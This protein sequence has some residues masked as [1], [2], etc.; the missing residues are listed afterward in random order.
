MLSPNFTLNFSFGCTN[1]F[2]FCPS[3]FFVISEWWSKHRHIFDNDDANQTECRS[4][5]QQQQQKFQL[6]HVTTPSAQLSSARHIFFITINFSFFLRSTHSITH[7]YILGFHL[8]VHNV[9]RAKKSFRWSQSSSFLSRECHTDMCVARRDWTRDGSD[10]LSRAAVTA[11]KLPLFSPL[12][13]SRFGGTEHNFVGWFLFSSFFFAYFS[14]NFKPVFFFLVRE[15]FKLSLFRLW[16]KYLKC[17]YV[18][19]FSNSTHHAHTHTYTFAASKVAHKNSSSPAFFPRCQT[20]PDLSWLVPAFTSSLAPSP[21]ARLV[22]SSAQRT[23]H[24]LH[25]YW[26]PFPI[27]AIF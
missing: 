17:K 14:L 2:F 5:K 13:L 1:V 23:R 3:V 12:N 6:Y 20:C 21:S 25:S 10:T 9:L 4:L 24:V 11:N 15:M 26:G 18:H 27:C 19:N 16:R 22:R 7:I 8:C